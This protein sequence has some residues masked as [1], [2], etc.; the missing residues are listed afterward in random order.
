MDLHDTIIVGG[1]I[2]GLIVPGFYSR[3][4]RRRS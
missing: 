1:E 2:A 4:D 3:M